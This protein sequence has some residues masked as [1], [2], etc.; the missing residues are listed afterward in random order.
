M[1]RILF[2][3]LLFLLPAWA[4][5]AN[6]ADTSQI[7]LLLSQKSVCCVVPKHAFEKKLTREFNTTATGTTAIFNKHGDISVN[8]WSEKK[9]KIEITIT[10]NALNQKEA[11]KVLA[12][13]NVNFI[14]T[15]GYVKAETVIGKL[16]CNAT[17]AF[18]VNYN[19]WIPLDNQLELSNKY[20]D[21]ELGNL[22]GNL[23][24]NIK[25]G[26]LKAGH[27]YAD[28]NLKADF[29]KTTISSVKNLYGWSNNGDIV[30]DDAKLVQME[31]E[32]TNCTFRRVEDIRLTANFGHVDIGVAER[33]VLH[34]KYGSTNIMSVGTMVLSSCHGQNTIKSLSKRL[35]ADLQ[36]GGLV[37][38]SIQNG[39]EKIELTGS[40]T[41]I[42]I[43]CSNTSYC[44]EV[45][46]N[47]TQLC[48]PS[49]GPNASTPKSGTEKSSPTISSLTR[50]GCLGETSTQSKITAKMNYGGL[51]LN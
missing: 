44:Y 37:I 13:I 42:N 27:L 3:V 29:C 22:K 5:A 1:T 30:L 51:V 19:V 31:T 17:D 43:K 4:N 26:D 6:W 24:A 18:K 46:G 12:Q 21:S 50:Q 33:I 2:N 8:V 49:S 36:S 39:F 23:T 47:N 45:S 9:V 34:T 40:H 14:G 41:A 25:F 20:G 48:L 11:D 7:H 32:R 38:N 28:A 35:N 10:V 15:S 16:D